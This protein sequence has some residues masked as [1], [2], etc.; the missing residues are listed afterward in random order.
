MRKSQPAK[1][2]REGHMQR[3]WGRK[4]K[5]GPRD[6]PESSMAGEVSKEVR[7]RRGG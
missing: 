7:G 4:S 2:Q 6:C 5:A 3:P 1:E